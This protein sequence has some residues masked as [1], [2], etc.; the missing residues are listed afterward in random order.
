M[1]S[2]N[3]NSDSVVDLPNLTSVTVGVIAGFSMAGALY[4]D[5]YWNPLLISITWIGFTTTGFLLTHVGDE[6]SESRLTPLILLFIL[7]ASQ[8]VIFSNVPITESAG[9]SVSIFILGVSSA[10]MLVGVVIGS[11]S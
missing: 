7:I 1:G 6:L 9:V 10:T 5:G 4:V 11:K 2:N 3:E 8:T